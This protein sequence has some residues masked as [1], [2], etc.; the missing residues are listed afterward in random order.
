MRHRDRLAVQSAAGGNTAAGCTNG[1]LRSASSTLAS[2]RAVATYTNEPRA[3][4][5][6]LVACYTAPWMAVFLCPAFV[7]HP[8]PQSHLAKPEKPIRSP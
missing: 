3:P 8:G 4:T 5:G 7:W 6:S 2:L 1:D